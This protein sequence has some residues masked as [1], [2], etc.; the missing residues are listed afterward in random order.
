[1]SA[2]TG[3]GLIETRLL[4]TFGAVGARAG[5]AYLKNSRVL[6]ALDREHQ[7]APLV[8][9]RVL[10]DLTRPYVSNLPV[11]DFNGNY[12]SP[13]FSE[14]SARYTE[15]RLSALGDAALEADRGERPA[16]PIGLVNGTTH[17]DG[18]MPPFAPDSVVS[19]LLAADA[20][21]TDQE[22]IETIGLPQFPTGCAVIADLEQLASGEATQLR[23]E[24]QVEIH[25]DRAL[26]VSSL[27]PRSSA[28]DIADVIDRMV[29]RDSEAW[30][31]ADVNDESYTGA[32]LVTAQLTAGADA[33]SVAQQLSEVWGVHRIV[34][35][36][37]T[38][39][40]PT[41]L[42]TWIAEHG[43][44]DLNAQLQPILTAAHR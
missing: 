24:A 8:G 44:S 31:I 27:P 19:A 36:K 35:V 17:L 33:T 3:L 30:P 15:S 5:C 40:L 22:L 6:E 9:Y 32:T 11:I 16:I 4:A 38:A 25:D 10:C 43:T 14:A 37:L 2:A 12:G 7:I 26:H 28:S 21:A 29:R 18:P 39:P 1:M 13:D 20:N 34:R 41:L 42:R 23:L